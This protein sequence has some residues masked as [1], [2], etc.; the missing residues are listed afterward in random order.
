MKRQLHNDIVYLHQ[1]PYLFDGSVFD[2]VAYGLRVKRADKIEILDKVNAA[3]E[4]VGL[5]GLASR[6]AN[7]LSGG[8]KQRLALAR[9]YVLKP[10]ILLLDEPTANMDQSSR[11]Q[12]FEV[13][14]QLK[15]SGIALIISHH[16]H[17][18]IT[19]LGDVNLHLEDGKMRLDHI[20]GSTKS[21][22]KLVQ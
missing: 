5:S 15:R 19:A 11:Q 17:D 13:L 18:A 21:P 20:S 22:L 14:T 1:T 10:S 12:T 6:D 16:T 4:F 8:E 7:R 9:A 2:N 3:L